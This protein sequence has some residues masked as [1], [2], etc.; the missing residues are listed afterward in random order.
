MKSDARD[1]LKAALTRANDKGL[2][3]HDYGTVDGEACLI[4]HMCILLCPNLFRYGELEYREI[5]IVERTN[6][7]EIG[8]ALQLAL[9]AAGVRGGTAGGLTA[10]REFVRWSANSS[11]KL[12]KEACRIALEG[13]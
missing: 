6:Q 7:A 3:L 10:V 12:V 1:L 13:N 8:G 5:A 11:S 2:L 4:A 9:R